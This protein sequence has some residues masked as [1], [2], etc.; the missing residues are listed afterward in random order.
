MKLKD[1]KTDLVRDKF[2]KAVRTCVMYDIVYG[3]QSFINIF[4][5]KTRHLELSIHIN[6]RFIRL[7]L[8]EM[9]F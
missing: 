1:E 2:P 3:L 8:S 5:D 7:V 9:I 6:Y 4:L